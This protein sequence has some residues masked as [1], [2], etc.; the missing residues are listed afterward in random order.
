MSRIPCSAPGCK[1]ISVASAD[2]KRYCN[3]HWLRMY[4][5]GDLELHPRSKTTKVVEVNGET[6]T[7]RMT[8]GTDI[9]IDAADIQKAM[10]YSW[11]LSKTGYAVA[12]IDGHVTKMHRYLLDMPVGVG[13]VD[14]ING[15]PL[16]NRRCNLRLCTAKENGRNLRKQ[17]SKSNATGVRKTKCGKWQA[18]IMVDRKEISLGN[19][20][21]MEEAIMARQ[22]GERKYYGKFAP[23][24]SRDVMIEEV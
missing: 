5:H 19:Y 21:T 2:G 14:H 3:K 6:A 12:N 1:A 10:R 11:C 18:R 23:C 9:L 17:V 8:N 13:I 4:N 24:L 20:Q 7:L 15:N 16:D 22:E